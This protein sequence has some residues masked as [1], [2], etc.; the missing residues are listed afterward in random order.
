MK[1]LI[2]TQYFHPENFRINDLAI[3]FQR[4]GHKITVLTGV[5]N[6][7]D[8]IFYNGYGI[9]KKNRETLKGIKIYRAPV[10]PRGSGS[11]FGLALNYFS[12]VIGGI[13]TALFLLA[14]K[15]DIIFV[16]EPSPITVG[17]PAI[18]IKKIKK[19]P[20]CFWVLDLWPESVVSAGN[21]KSGLIPRMLNPIV[22][23]IYKHSDKILVSSNGFIKSIEDKGVSRKKIECFPQWAE[24]LFKPVKSEK[25][26]LG[27]IPKESFKIMFAGNIGEAQ[28][29]PSILEAAKILKHDENIHWVILGA[30]RKE[31]WVKSKINE[32]KLENCFHMLGSFP[33]DDMPKYYAR[34]DVMLVSL[35][36]EYI[37][38][39]TIPAK[40]Q[41]YLACS[42]PILAMVDVES[43]ALVREAKA[44]LTCGSGD[45]EGLANNILKLSKYDKEIIINIGL[46]A[47]KFY[48][49]NFEREMLFQKAEN[50]FDTLVSKV[51]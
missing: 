1:I 49:A 21:L 38:S 2:V 22:K 51:K 5:P 19:I 32:Y 37:Y 48:Q 9:L 50:I 39:L 40:V 7:P 6:Y 36:K 34:A 3:E 46:N 42:K 8:G 14:H 27:K 17:I 31:E 13:F 11:T 20:I 26:L 12:F 23:F 47:Y 4:R 44:G 25:Y 45:A 24:P 28:D 30:G 35:K 16:Y 43:S 18:F 33:L 15:L 10:I 41:S 29:F